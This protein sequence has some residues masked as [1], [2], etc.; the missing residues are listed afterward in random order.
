MEERM[1]RCHLCNQRLVGDKRGDGEE[2]TLK[3]E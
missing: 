3:K 1:E 2:A